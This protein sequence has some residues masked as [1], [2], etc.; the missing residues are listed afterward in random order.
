[1][2]AAV[3]LPTRCPPLLPPPRCRRAAAAGELPLPPPQPLSNNKFGHDDGNHAIFD[4]F[5]G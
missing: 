2:P 1:M 3:A 5:F 4:K